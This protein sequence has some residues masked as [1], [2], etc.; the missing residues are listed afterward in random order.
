ML[1]GCIHQRVQ[2]YMRH[3]RGLTALMR[4]GAMLT[5]SATPPR[6]LFLRESAY[7]RRVVN[8]GMSGQMELTMTSNA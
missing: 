8:T 3:C 5:T 7:I 4:K 6:I 1:C 2:D